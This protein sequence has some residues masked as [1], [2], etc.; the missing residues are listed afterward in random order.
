MGSRKQTLIKKLSDGSDFQ[1]QGRE[2]KKNNLKLEFD[3]S[4]KGNIKGMGLSY[5][6]TNLG[7]DKNPI[8]MKLYDSETKKPKYNQISFEKCKIPFMLLN[9]IGNA[10]ENNVSIEFK[11]I[12]HKA[13]LGNYKGAISRLLVPDSIEVPLNFNNKARINCK[14]F[15]PPSFIGYLRSGV[16]ISLS[17]GIDFTGSNVYYTEP[18]SLHY[19][20]NGMNDYEKAISSCGD[21]LSYYDKTQLFAVYGFGFNLKRDMAN[22]LDCYPINND[23]DNPKIHL[24]NNVLNVYRQFIKQIILSGP[25]NFAP[26]INELNKT[27]KE[28]LKNGL[29]LKYNILL[30]LT[31]G[32]I[33]DFQNT[34]DALVEASFLPISVIIVGIG[35]G[36]FG[37]MNDLDADK[38]LLYYR[39]RRKVDRDLVQF[40]PFDKYKN[41]PPKLAEQVLEEIPRQLVEYY[42][43]QN[44]YPEVEA[45]EKDISYN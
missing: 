45:D 32:K 33:D 29:I 42:L 30:I 13:I 22:N 6:I 38:Y 11:D 26:M 34:I 10:E 8:A 28:D 9:P 18:N 37:N 25:T 14:L 12:N 21:I 23:K 44:I 35:N 4:I 3:I 19:L 27:V 31:D 2:I 39:S 43:H 1:V 20:N 5:T 41:D 17:I 7:T 16:Q 24:I 15:A 40:V 36:D